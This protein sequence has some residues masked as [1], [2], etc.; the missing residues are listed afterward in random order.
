MCLT[1]IALLVMTAS[2]ANP[3]DNSAKS[4]PAEKKKA[5]PKKVDVLVKVSATD[6]KALPGG[7]VVEI[8]GQ[9][10]TCG[11]LNVSDAQST[12]DEKGE[13]L[14]RDIPACKV[15]VKINLNE[16]M[17]VRKA[18]DLSGYKTCVPARTACDAILL[19][20]EPL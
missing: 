16:Y 19:V 2:M 20:L 9:E 3:Q 4:K 15:T 18:V 17:P 8:S 1:G 13:A 5:D 10:T 11:S 6:G 14:F 7:A 12:L